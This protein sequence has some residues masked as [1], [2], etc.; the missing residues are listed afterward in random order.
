MIGAHN[1]IEFLKGTR[2]RFLGHVVWWIVLV[3][4]HC[5]TLKAYVDPHSAT[6]NE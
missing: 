5:N 2:N 4:L 3:D 6:Q 1:K